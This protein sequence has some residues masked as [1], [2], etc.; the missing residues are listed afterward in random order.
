MSLYTFS[1]TSNLTLLDTPGEVY[2][3][4]CQDIKILSSI[5]GLSQENIQLRMDTGHKAFLAYYQYQPAAF[6]WMATTQATIGELNHSFRLPQRER[7]LWNFRTLA[8]FRGKGI[9]PALLQY[10]LWSEAP[11]AHRFWIAH[12]PEN[13]ASLRGITKA[14]FQF[15]GTLYRNKMGRVVIRE[16]EANLHLLPSL[17]Q[18]GIYRSAA[19]AASCWQ[20]SSP[21]VKNRTGECCCTEKGQSCNGATILQPVV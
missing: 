20:C 6:G 16:N 10:I 2:L 12:A 7:Y 21:Y 19:D 8:P 18:M 13:N 9:Y 15:A 5:S 17:Y 1:T 11:K 4:T 14:G 3:E